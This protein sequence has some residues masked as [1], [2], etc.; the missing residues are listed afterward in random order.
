M[1]PELEREGAEYEPPLLG[2][3]YERD[4][5]EYD[6]LTLVLL[7]GEELEY[8]GADSLELVR[9]L[10][11]IELLTVLFPGAVPFDAEELLGLV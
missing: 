6:L 4:G 3:E 1:L 2:D 9:E 8:D 7:A 11:L 10:L 5:A